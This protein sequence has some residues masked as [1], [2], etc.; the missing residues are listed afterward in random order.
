MIVS[1]RTTRDSVPHGGTA[2]EGGAGLTPRRLRGQHWSNE[3]V[4]MAA[5]EPPQ[6]LAM[7]VVWLGEESSPPEVKLTR[8]SGLLG[9]VQLALEEQPAP[10][11][12][13]KLLQQAE[14]PLA[15]LRQAPV[16]GHRVGQLTQVPSLQLGVAPMGHVPHSSV[17]PQPSGA[18]PQV[19]PSSAQVFGMQTHWPLRH[20]PCGPQ[21]TPS[22]QTPSQHWPFWQQGLPGEP[23]RLLQPP[24]SALHTVAGGPQH[25]SPQLIVAGS[26]QHV[27]PA[28]PLEGSSQS[29]P[30]HVATWS[31]QW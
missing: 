3:E 8:Q 5:G 31:T 21:Q 17:P 10:Q 29:L 28:Q 4:Q 23:Q 7:V 20:S 15:K 16:L 13:S 22:Q 24:S 27:S 2:A 1:G 30:A 25:E 12:I 9:S 14:S 11:L 18:V 19:R 6:M 26:P